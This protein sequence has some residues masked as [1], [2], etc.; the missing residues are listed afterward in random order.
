MAHKYL[1]RWINEYVRI[2]GWFIILDVKLSS[3]AW[4]IVKKIIHL[5]K[6]P[7]LVF[8]DSFLN[9]T[10]DRNQILTV[11]DENSDHK[12]QNAKIRES[13]HMADRIWGSN[14]LFRAFFLGGGLTCIAI[15][16]KL[17]KKQPLDPKVY[18]NCSWT[19]F[20]FW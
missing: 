1:Q 19:K 2:L 20:L 3:T 17:L 10:A 5:L 9:I 6:L 11:I 14:I 13:S 15:K 7:T 18:K 16:R 4:K 8:K 12:T